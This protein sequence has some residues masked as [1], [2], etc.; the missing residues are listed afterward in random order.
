MNRARVIEAFKVV[1]KETGLDYARSSASCCT[2]CMNYAL[3]EKYGETS[4]GIFL[5]YFETGVNK[6][7]WDEEKTYAIN[8]DLTTEQANKVVE[9][10]K[11]YFKVNWSGSDSDTIKISDI[12]TR[13][14]WFVDKLGV[15]D[16]VY[17]ELL[18]DMKEL[19]YNTSDYTYRIENALTLQEAKDYLEWKTG[20]NDFDLENDLPSFTELNQD[21]Q[22]LRVKDLYY[23][24]KLW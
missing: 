24:I 19:E 17:F 1:K 18:K 8:H 4:K 10:L 7:K 5:R 14:G 12:G 11:R 6:E 21:F 13:E 22:F 23:L 20:K 3:S 9:V 16:E 2:S 15:N